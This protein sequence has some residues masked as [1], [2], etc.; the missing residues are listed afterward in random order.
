[1]SGSE[2]PIGALGC[3]PA[4][5][6]H[7]RRIAALAA[8]LAAAPLTAPAATILKIATLA[9]EGSAWMRTLEQLKDEVATLS[10]GEV[11]LRIYPAGI[12]GEE[13]DV[14]MKIRA[15][16]LDGG[17]FLGNGIA[18]ICPEANALMLPLTFQDHAEV[19]AAMAEL[20][21][22][23]EER[24]LANGFVVLGWT[25]VGFS[26]LFSNRQIRTLD[27]LRRAK[28]W[29]L[30]NEP[31]LAEL[32]RQAGVGAVPVPVAD[33]LT[34]LQTGLLDTVYSPPLAAVAMQWTGRVKHFNEL[35]LAYSFGGLFIA[36]RAWERVPESFRAPI[37][38]AAR[39]RTAELTASVRRS[40]EEAL[41]VMRKA[42][43]TPVVT[44][45]EEV[46]RFREISERTR[47]AL[48]GSLVPAEA[49]D[50]VQQF[51]RRRRGA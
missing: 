37:L 29:A 31:M 22:W 38:Q 47:A 15:G 45:P 7:P 51:L 41:D 14:L 21:P 8:V 1:M 39:R 46:E 50:R 9:P 2:G 20:G 40:N 11:R 17:G 12:M 18:R 30:P 13:K 26:L 44:P 28:V 23:L 43:L 27:D 42:G 34:A 33:V 25:E 24:S 19:D 36:R 16:Q 6:R 32:F 35:R 10:Q 48:R 49:D 5:G 4:A 3:V